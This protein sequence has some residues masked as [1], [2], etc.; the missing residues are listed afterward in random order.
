[1]PTHGDAFTYLTENCLNI[2]GPCESLLYVGHRGD[3]HPWWYQT[4]A[5]KL[6]ITRLAVLDVDKG[7][8]ESAAHITKELYLGDIRQTDAPRGFDIVFWDEGPEHLPKDV[9]LRLC[10]HLASVNRRALISCPWGYMPQGRDPNDY[11]FHHWGP[12]LEDFQSIGWVA[13]TFGVEHP[14]GHGNLIAWSL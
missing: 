9:S 1:M 11:E 13:L 12:Q 6:G 3:T 10:E 4:F 2:F 14:N 7:N 5:A 8:L